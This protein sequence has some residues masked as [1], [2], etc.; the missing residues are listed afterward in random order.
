MKNFLPYPFPNREE[1]ESHI[2][3]VIT[4]AFTHI[5]PIA[6]HD[7]ATTAG[8]IAAK[9]QSLFPFPSHDGSGIFTAEW[10]EERYEHLVASMDENYMKWAGMN[11]ND[12]ELR[13]FRIRMVLYNG[14][15]IKDG[16]GGV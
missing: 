14:P 9:L 3:S 4:I 15:G 11:T 2:N 8:K 10:V 13:D 1:L 7:R 6:Q 16:W 5:F 12:K